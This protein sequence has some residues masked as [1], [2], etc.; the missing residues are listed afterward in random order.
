MERI[1]DDDWAEGQGVKIARVEEGGQRF[2]PN[3]GAGK[4]MAAG[5]GRFFEHGDAEGPFRPPGEANGAGKAGRTGSDDQRVGVQM[6]LVGIHDEASGAGK[7]LRND[8]TEF[9][10]RGKDWQLDKMRG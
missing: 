1:A 9:R 5:M 8:G 4:Q 7:G 10:E 3:D 6:A 2:G